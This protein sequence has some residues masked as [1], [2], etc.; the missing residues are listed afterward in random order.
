MSRES[1]L[2]DALS[3]QPVSTSALYDRI[4]YP[5][6]ARLG[7]IPYVEFRAALAAL[8]SDGRAHSETA[9]DGSTMW[10]R[11]ERAG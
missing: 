10:S 2:I 7:L 1:V 9:D 5:T 4:G 6:L 3:A 8:E 11:T